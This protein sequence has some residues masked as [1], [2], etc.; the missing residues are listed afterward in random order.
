[1]AAT[2]SEFAAFAARA[3]DV[4]SL[5]HELSRLWDQHTDDDG[6]V[7]RAVMSNLLIISDGTDDETTLAEEIATIVQRHPSRVLLLV[8][9][10]TATHEVRA[11]VAAHCWLAGRGRQICS[12]HV[13]LRTHGD[14]VE[15]LASVA[16]SLLLGDLPTTLWWLPAQP[17]GDGRWRDAA[18]LAD[19]IIYDGRRFRDPLPALF[20]V[21][22][23]R[24]AHDHPVPMSDLAWRR[25]R[26]WRHV[27][28]DGLDPACAPGALRRVQ[29]VA[30]DHGERGGAAA[31]LLLGWL[32]NR[33]DGLATGR[34]PTFA[35][36]D[37][38]DDDGDLARLQLDLGDGDAVVVSRESG[39]LTLQRGA[40]PRVV[41]AAPARRRADLIADE[42]RR[43]GR[44]RVQLAA[45][46][47]AL[48]VAERTG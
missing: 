21:R 1:V 45:F 37:V 18:A 30:L 11:S 4:R 44:D 6:D 22:R 38:N 33:L 13:T 14:D 10:D 9:D 23:W 12:E 34:P 19:R 5:E 20:A 7:T 46:D 41:R 25:L 29:G 42:L 43:L 28:A 17:P 39:R 47:T 26:P 15:R 8:A 48:D 36:L 16:R 27:L 3:V 40:E 32:A 24:A 2:V 35:R 31:W